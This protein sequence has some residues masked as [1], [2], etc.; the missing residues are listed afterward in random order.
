MGAAVDPAGHLYL[1][2]ALASTVLKLN[3]ETLRNPYVTF[4][5]E[6]TGDSDLDA[7]VGIAVDDD[8][9]VYVADQKNFRVQKFSYATGCS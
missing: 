6:G 7:P 2:D 4:G 3:P 1:T 9:N 5:G 8:C